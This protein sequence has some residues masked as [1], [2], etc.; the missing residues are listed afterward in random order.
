M[1]QTLPAEVDLDQ[2]EQDYETDPDAP[3]QPWITDPY[4][5][6]ANAESF[7]LVGVRRSNPNGCPH[8]GF[9]PLR[10]RK[11]EVCLEREPT[12]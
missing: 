2:F 9:P 12:A 4:S 8:P 3:V 6:E 7:D 1:T 11:P 10:R 5:P